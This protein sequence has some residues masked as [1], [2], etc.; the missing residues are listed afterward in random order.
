MVEFNKTNDFFYDI[1]EDF[2][3]T[4][5]SEI[6]ETLKNKNIDESFKKQYVSKYLYIVDGMS[7]SKFNM[8]HFFNLKKNLIYLFF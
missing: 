1:E 4:Q 5:L 6:I 7:K 2:N 8:E 3:S